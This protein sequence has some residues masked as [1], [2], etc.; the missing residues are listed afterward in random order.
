[1]A[2]LP[3]SVRSLFPITET[4]VYLNHASSGPLSR[5]ARDRMVQVLDGMMTHGPLIADQMEEM[6]AEARASAARLVHAQPHQIAFLRNT[7]DA[8]SAIANGITWRRGDNIV[9]T[10]VEFPA[11]AYPWRRV[12]ALYGVELRV[13]NPGGRGLVDMEQLLALVDERTRVVTV[14]WVQFASGQRLNIR[15]IGKY[16]RERN[17]LFVVDAIQGLGA[18]QLDVEKDFVD[19]FAAGANKFLL[20]AKG[21]AL[22]YV[23]D[24]AVERVQ[25]AVIGWTAV[26]DYSDY[27]S[28][29]TIDFRKGAARYEG[30]VSN[31]AGICGLGASIDLFLHVGPENIERHIL[32]LG[33]YL[34]TR[35]KERGYQV[36]GSQ[37][38]SQAS[39]ITV[40][41]HDRYSAEEI[42]SRLASRN[43]LTSARQEGLRISPHLYN[44]QADMDALLTSLPG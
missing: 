14:S 36:I 20:S 29:P 6:Q 37:S 38:P 42:C 8:I 34:S 9:S 31:V 33:A 40:C 16:C 2:T 41:K 10:A 22:L 30:G 26:K 12:A 35:L 3:N 18:L 17:I 25:P 27:V 13:T 28:H 23:S 7:S 24:R 21:I 43:I 39:S 4:C 15:Q 5:P 44:S 1:M 32:S 11:N 19:A